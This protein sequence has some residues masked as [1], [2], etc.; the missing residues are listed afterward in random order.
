MTTKQLKTA[1]DSD[2]KSK[3]P[4]SGNVMY[5]FVIAQMILLIH[6]TCQQNQFDFGQNFSFPITRLAYLTIF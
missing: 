2:M 1:M 3:T 5:I 4:K 6:C